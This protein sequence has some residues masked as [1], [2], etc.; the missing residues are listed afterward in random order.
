MK[1]YKTTLKL[2][3]ILALAFMFSSHVNASEVTGSL[4]SSEISDE[5]ETNT[6]TNGSLS[7]TVVS[8]SQRSNKGAIAGTV[9]SDDSNGDG[10]ENTLIQQNG[11]AVSSDQSNSMSS[12]G[13][14]LVPTADNLAF[15]GNDDLFFGEFSTEEPEDST[16]LNL[17]ASTAGLNVGKLTWIMLLSLSAI[18]TTMYINTRMSRS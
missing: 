9:E 8:S 5:E 1:Y 6:N 13:T 17:S 7:G 15:A 18:A 12:D 3:L 4:S 11:S 14:A 2:F 16:A 10:N